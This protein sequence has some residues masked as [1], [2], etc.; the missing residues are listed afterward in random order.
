MKSKYVIAIL[1]AFVIIISSVNTYASLQVKEENEKEGGLAATDLESGVFS[2]KLGVGKN[3]DPLFYLKGNFEKKD[4]IIYCNG[5][6]ICGDKE[7]EFTG[8][9]KGEYFEIKITFEEKSKIMIG[10][11]KLDKN[12]EDFKG[13]WYT[14]SKNEDSKD[15][16]KCFDFVYPIYYTLPD[17][18]TITVESEDDWDG[19]KNWYETNPG[20][21]EKPELQYPVDIIF[22]DG[23][24]K[25]INNEKEM[26]G[27]YEYCWKKDSGWIKG[28]FQG[29]KENIKGKNIPTILKRFPMGAKLLEMQIFQRILKYI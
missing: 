29:L 28:T 25:T 3:K 8:I 4:K 14:D 27:V 23:T 2:A 5:I 1:C 24:I 21:K 15:K 22:E 7:G 17:G 13:E 10:K 20:F 26:K 19:I 12:K 11:L 9:I 18:S 16:T 6:V